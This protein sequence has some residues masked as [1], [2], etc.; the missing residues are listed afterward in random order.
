MIFNAVEISYVNE[1][2]R[3]ELAGYDSE[4]E[5]EKLEEMAAAEDC[6]YSADRKEESIEKH[7][8]CISDDESHQKDTEWSLVDQD[9]RQ[10]LG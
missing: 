4:W 6:G 5:A 2:F 10:A 8:F 9:S 7:N 1:Q 3:R